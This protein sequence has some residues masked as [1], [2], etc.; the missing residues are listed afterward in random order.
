MNLSRI[1]QIDAAQQIEQGRLPAA[2]GTQQGDERAA[3][4]VQIETGE[5]TP[6][7]LAFG[8][9]SGQLPNLDENR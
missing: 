3:L 6:L 1:R 8:I 7:L 4:D 5:N 2:G 9:P